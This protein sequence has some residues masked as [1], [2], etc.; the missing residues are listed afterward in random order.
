MLTFYGGVKDENS[1]SLI[2]Y[3]VRI[4]NYTRQ[5]RKCE[6]PIILHDGQREK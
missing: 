2:V 5:T 4:L 6:Q 1:I 3:Y